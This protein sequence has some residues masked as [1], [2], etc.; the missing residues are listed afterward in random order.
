MSR[1]VTKLAGSQLLLFISW[2]V[3]AVGLLSASTSDSANMS[4]S[5]LKATWIVTLVVLGIAGTVAVFRS[6]TFG[7][8][9]VTALAA[10]SVIMYGFD[11]HVPGLHA[12][13][14][15][16]TILALGALATFFA[17]LTAGMMPDPLDLQ[18][19]DTAVLESI[20][21]LVPVLFIRTGWAY[22]AFAITAVGLL[23]WWMGAKQD[24]RRESEL[25][26]A[27]TASTT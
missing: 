18:V 19:R 2:L 7:L 16:G 11:Q 25:P 5:G 15:F 20:G 4:A 8:A 26:N 23:A 17:W 14:V 12:Y 1:I 10:V 6:K 27:I 9:A 21:V 13:V 3:A 22:A 24:V